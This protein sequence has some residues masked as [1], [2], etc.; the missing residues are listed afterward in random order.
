M[1]GFEI[2]FSHGPLVGCTVTVLWFNLSLQ[3]KQYV[4]A[5]QTYKLGIK[6]LRGSVSVTVQSNSGGDQRHEN[7]MLHSDGPRQLLNLCYSNAALCLLHLVS[8][9]PASS[10]KRGTLGEPAQQMVL[11]CIKYCKL[12]TELDPNYAKSWFRLAKASSRKYFS[13][14]QN[15]SCF[16]KL[17]TYVFF[18]P[19]CCQ[20]LDFTFG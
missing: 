1:L 17:T 7:T 10:S 12:A 14:Y 16:A 19:L 18:T 11:L 2:S 4:R 8:L 13:F 5:F 6:F 9:L 15:V 3:T 20:V